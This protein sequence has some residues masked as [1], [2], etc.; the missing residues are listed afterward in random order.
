MNEA[1]LID[2]KV[3]KS[4]AETSEHGE[5]YRAI[6]RSR[7]YRI[8]VGARLPSSGQAHYFLEVVIY[9][10]PRASEVNI[11]LLEKSL[12]FLKDLQARRY[13]LS[14]EDDGSISCEIVLKPDELDSEYGAVKASIKK[15]F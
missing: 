9:L 6:E 8:G 14:C 13:S 12:T 15:I 10:C 2:T 1:H 11:P 5:S 4:E 3:L 7:N